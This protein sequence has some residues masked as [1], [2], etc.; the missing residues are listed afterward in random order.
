[1]TSSGPLVR[2]LLDG[3]SKRLGE[4]NLLLDA[5]SKGPRAKRVLRRIIAQ[6]AGRCDHPP[7]AEFSMVLGEELGIAHQRDNE[8]ELTD[9]G[10]CLL[11]VSTWPPHD[12][13]NSAQLGLLSPEMIGHPEL[14]RPI[15]SALRLMTRMRDSSRLYRLNSTPLTP[16]QVVA[17]QVLQ[18]THFAQVEG[19]SIRVPKERFAVLNAFLGGLSSRSEEEL[20]E[21]LQETRTRAQRAEEYVVQYEHRRLVQ[22]NRNDLAELVERVSQYDVHASFDVRSFDCS[23]TIR[24]IEVK[25][26]T[27]RRVQFYWTVAERD[28]AEEKGPAYWIYFV[29]RSQELPSLRY[30]LVLIQDPHALLGETLREECDTYKVTSMEAE[31]TARLVQLGAP[32][33]AT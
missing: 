20:W 1:M 10:R 13:L 21:S 11:E 3:N 4:I 24:Y 12:R 22:A 29:P 23:G 27:S 18:A 31:R 6:M 9:L 33:P 28:F 5:L 26:S 25:S 19:E 17:F 2:V 7:D 32:I 30:P 16:A 14:T 8:M 15:I